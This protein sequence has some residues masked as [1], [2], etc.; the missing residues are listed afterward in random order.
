MSLFFFGR[1]AP[2]LRTLPSAGSACVFK[3]SSSVRPRVIVEREQPK[4][5]VTYPHPPWGNMSDKDAA[6]RRL[7]FSESVSKTAFSWSVFSDVKGLV[8][9]C[10]GLLLAKGEVIKWN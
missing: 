10:I 5:L 8:S 1:P 7:S 9:K 4:I 2:F 3:R 6:K